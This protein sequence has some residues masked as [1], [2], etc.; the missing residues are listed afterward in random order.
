QQTSPPVQFEAPRH[1]IAIPVPPSPPAS[2]DASGDQNVAPGPHS[3][4]LS[5]PSMAVLVP[6]FSTRPHTPVATS[7]SH[8]S[9]RMQSASATLISG[10]VVE[11]PA[12]EYVHEILVALNPAQHSCRCAAAF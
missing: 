10:Y 7:S 5:A 6:G 4:G 3:M 1:P 9:P 11:H 12:D 8:D 2:S